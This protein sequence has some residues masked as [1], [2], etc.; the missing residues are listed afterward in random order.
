MEYI[1]ADDFYRRANQL[2][3]QTMVDLSERNEAIDVITIADKLE[4]KNQLEDI[5]GTPY[6]ADIATTVLTAANVE[7]YSKIVEERSYTPSSD[8]DSY[9]N[10]FKRI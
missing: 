6:L 2:I 5:G 1:E 9:G 3:F 10:C 4:S 7:Y 8:S